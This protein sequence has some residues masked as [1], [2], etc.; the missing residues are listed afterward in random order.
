MG[1]EQKYAVPKKDVLVRDPATKHPLPEVGGY[2]PWIGPVGRYWRR[3]AKEGS[4]IV[5]E[6]KPVIKEPIVEKTTIKKKSKVEEN[7]NGTYI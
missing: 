6:E 5:T 4:I 7:I 3:R 1:A 2:V